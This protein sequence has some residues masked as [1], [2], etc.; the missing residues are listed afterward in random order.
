MQT[1]SIK[2]GKVEW[3]VGQGERL[4]QKGLLSFDSRGF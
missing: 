3:Q 1:D 2:K 4:T